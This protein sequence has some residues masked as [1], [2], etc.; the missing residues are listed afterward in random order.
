MDIGILPLDLLKAGYDGKEFHAVVG[1]EAEA[2]A[3]FFADAA[4]L[5]DDS[6]ASGARIPA[7]SAVRKKEN[8]RFFLIHQC[9]VMKNLFVRQK[10]SNFEGSLYIRV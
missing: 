4:S 3:E 7:C 1:R 2:S 5:E 6:V 9:K 10:K 8:W